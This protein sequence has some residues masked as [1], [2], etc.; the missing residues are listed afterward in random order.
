MGR[1]RDGEPVSLQN[2]GLSTSVVRRAV[3]RLETVATGNASQDP[4][5]GDAHSVIAMS[6]RT[7]VCLPLPSPR[8][9]RRVLGALYVDNQASSAPFSSESLSVAEALARHAALAI[10]NAQLFERERRT[11][12]ELRRTQNQLLQSEKL[13][14]VGQ[15][16]AGIAHELNTPLT[17]ILGNIELLVSDDELTAAQKT[18]L[19]RVAKGAEKIQTLAQNLLA[20]SRP[21][22]ND[23]SRLSV[24]SVID[25]S[26]DLCHYQILKASVQVE[27]DFTT[28]L[29]PVMGTANQL[30]M[31]IINLVVNAVHAMR[32]GGTLFVRSALHAEG[33]EI[34]VQDTG[35]GIPESIRETLFE[36][37]VTTKPA[38]EGTGLGLSTVLMVVEG[39]GGRVTYDTAT[40]KG[41]TFRIILPAAP[42]V[43]PVAETPQ[44]DTA[45]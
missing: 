36:P 8:G 26:L 38:G 41:T 5:L 14:L 44:D 37:F 27:K 34:A 25:R 2:P 22:S 10:E 45:F 42:D 40:D 16:A 35:P 43:P 23:R 7:I 29:P 18:L 21:S 1:H 30:E 24:N 13:A 17:Y 31:A 3:D 32:D 11:V 39:H 20:F 28:A 33:V 15:M 4:S 12:A 6:L 19:G 9:E